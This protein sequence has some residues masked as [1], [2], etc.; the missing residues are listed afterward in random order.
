MALGHSSL[1]EVGWSGQTTPIKKELPDLP[2]PSKRKTL[3][4][5]PAENGKV[6]LTYS[7]SIQKPKGAPDVSTDVT[8]GQM[9]ITLTPTKTPGWSMLIVE[10]LV[11]KTLEDHR[12]EHLLTPPTN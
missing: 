3:T 4:M 8:L 7:M 12:A 11:D 9:K 5:A 10:T 2:K 1:G 6:K